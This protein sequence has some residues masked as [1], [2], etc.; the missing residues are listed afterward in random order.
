MLG[1]AQRLWNSVALDMLSDEA[2]CFARMADLAYKKPEERQCA[3]L[4]GAGYVVDRT[5]ADERFAVFHHP[6]S[7]TVVVSF[8]GTASGGMTL[9]YDVV[10]E[11][12][13][14]HENPLNTG[15]ADM[16]LAAAHRT[17]NSK[18]EL[19]PRVQQGMELIQTVVRRSDYRN[20]A[21]YVTGHSLGGMVAMSCAV[22]MHEIKRGHVFN[23]GGGKRELE[24]L[25]V[26]DEYGSA[27]M[28]VEHHHIFGDPLSMFF[29]RGTLTVYRPSLW[30]VP[31]THTMHHF[32]P[33]LCGRE[34]TAGPTCTIS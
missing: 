1:A 20:H 14:K 16:N 29:S 11:L 26:G 33:E 32:I 15:G 10:K 24:R 28:K 13:G 17:R 30:H 23:A 9:L 12:G 18:G 4:E 5:M 19:P 6:R 34:A 2:I 7:R 25:L 31:N 22:R 27:S 21:V 8:R 3:K